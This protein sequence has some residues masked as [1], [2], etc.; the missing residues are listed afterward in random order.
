MMKSNSISR[1]PY[2]TPLWLPSSQLYFQ[3]SLNSV[4][5]NAYN[6]THPSS[7]RANLH[8]SLPPLLLSLLRTTRLRS[9]L[10]SHRRRRSSSR[11]SRLLHLYVLL[12]QLWQAGH[13]TPKPGEGEHEAS[14]LGGFV[15]AVFE[16]CTRRGVVGFEGQEGD[17]GRGCGLGGW[18]ARGRF[19]GVL[20][21]YAG[22]FGVIS[23]KLAEGRVA[24][25]LRE[26]VM[27]IAGR[28]LRLW[29]AP[30]GGGRTD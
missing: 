23:L 22:L 12:L 14:H 15:G 19:D 3:T 6:A 27:G 11:I 30:G 9:S 24:L 1:L 29:D 7:H 8:P 16:G 4:P 25:G 2:Y 10:L 5:Q 17:G 20:C 13:L 21:G 26:R 28:H 18:L